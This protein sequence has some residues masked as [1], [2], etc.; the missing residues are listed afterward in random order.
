MSASL[1]RAHDASETELRPGTV[2]LSGAIMQNVANI[3][4]AISGFF[5]T[6]TLVG[7]A[8][9]QAPLAYVFGLAI[10][11]ALGSCLVQLARKFP[12]AGGYFTYASRTLGPQ[13]GFLTG[14]MFVLY[15]PVCT[16]PS[17]AFLGQILE[18]ELAGNYGWHWFHWWMIVAAGIPLVAYTGYAGV[19]FS[20]RSIVVVGTA[21][22][23]IVIALG[24]SGLLDPGPGGFSL[25]PFTPG[26]NPGGIATFSGFVLAVVLTVQGLTGWEGAVPLAE[27]TIDPRRNVPRS[28]MASIVI[29][30]L[31]LVIAMWGQ[32]VGWGTDNLKALVSSAELPA[33][34]V[35]H[36]IWGSLWWIVLLAIFTSSFGVSFACQNVATR[37]WFAMGRSGVL[38]KAF[39]RVHPQR[40]TPTVAITA[41]A[42]LSVLVGLV[43]PWLMGPREFFIFLVG[44]V[45]VLAVIFIYVV[46][47]IGIIR[48]YWSKAP[49]EFSWLRHMLFPAGTSLVLVYSLYISFV[50]PPA[51]PDN[52]APWVAGIWLVLGL[53]ILGWMKIR[54]R[55]DWLS[56]AAEFIVG[57]EHEDAA[58][59]PRPHGPPL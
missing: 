15:S 27:E 52:W 49:G 6:Q 20:I 40:R 11:L 7:S 5:F 33:L 16:G 22:I 8:G 21:E 51:A 36:R 48:Y 43:L 13:L 44:F 19:S 47:N 9:A 28:I 12:S 39:G 3:A 50:P 37:M 38:P 31:M 32:V 25:Q 29:I 26:F 54:G 56:R 57:Q 53:A 1:A 35:A 30:G 23:L 42:V 59:E 41:Q 45:L 4:P 24:I 34:V 14:W 2:G 46:A 18:T 10:V 17:L 58:A 55:E